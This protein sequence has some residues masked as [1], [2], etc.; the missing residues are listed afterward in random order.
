[1]QI[2]PTI[3]APTVLAPRCQFWFKLGESYYISDSDTDRRASVLRRTVQSAIAAIP[4]NLGDLLDAGAKRV[5][6]DQFKREVVQRTIVGPT[7]TGAPMEVMYA[8]NGSIAGKG[9][10]PLEPAGSYRQ[11]GPLSGEWTIDEHDRICA[12]MRLEPRVGTVFPKSCQACFK[13]R[14]IYYVSDSDTDRRAKVL[15]RTIMP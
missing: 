2:A 1:M 8:P 4:G 10:N 14:E 11:G 6:A 5:T 13:L 3:G 15:S 9:G 12:T 7:N